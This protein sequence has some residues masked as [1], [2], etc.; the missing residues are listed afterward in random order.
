MKNIILTIVAAL[1]VNF[2]ALAAN[3]GTE[4]GTSYTT[5]TWVNG[6]SSSVGTWELSGDTGS[7]G[8]SPT[9]NYAPSF[10]IADSS[11]GGR[12]SIGTSA[13]T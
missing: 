4:S 7:R 9:I 2:S 10:S 5:S 8:T 11:Q 13:Y 12:A 1:A 3:I 6:A